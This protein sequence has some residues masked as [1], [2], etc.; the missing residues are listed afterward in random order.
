MKRRLRD[1]IIRMVAGVRGFERV[2]Y[3]MHDSFDERSEDTDRLQGQT[4][5]FADMRFSDELSRALKSM[6]SKTG[7]RG[8]PCPGLSAALSVQKTS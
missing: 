8:L 2:Q 1:I 3:M 7:N 5:D 6:A 4:I